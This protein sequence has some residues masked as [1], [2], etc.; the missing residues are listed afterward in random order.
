MSCS[1]GRA[2]PV[3]FN[4]LVFDQRTF[5]LNLPHS[6]EAIYWDDQASDGKGERAIHAAFCRK[7]GLGPQQVPFV[8]LGRGNGG[9]LFLP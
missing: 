5:E 1:L 8:R 7:F 3:N 2:A 9:P 6:V 4:E